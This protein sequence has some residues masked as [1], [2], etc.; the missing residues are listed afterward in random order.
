M[1]IRRHAKATINVYLYDDARQANMSALRDWP[2]LGYFV[3]ERSK[4][5]ADAFSA[6]VRK[7][8]A[9]FRFQP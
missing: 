5:I 8:I 6:G 1:D 2:T 3:R 9:R 7:A 4:Q